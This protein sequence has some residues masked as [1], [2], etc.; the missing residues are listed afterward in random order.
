MKVID[1]FCGAG[2]FSEGLR[3]AGHEVILAVDNWEPALKTHE[4]NHSDCEHWNDDIT[5]IP[6]ETYPKA[7]IIIGSPPCQKFSKA[8]GT[9]MD[10]DAE[11]T[12]KALQVIKAVKPKYWL[13]EN[14]SMW[15]KWVKTLGVGNHSIKNAMYC[16]VPQVRKRHFIGKIPPIMHVQKKPIPAYK[17][18]NLR[19]TDWVH[20]ETYHAQHGKTWKS[21]A[22]PMWTL[23]TK[24]RLVFHSKYD[25]DKNS[26]TKIRRITP[27]D[28][29]RLQAFPD[30][31]IFVGSK[32][33]LF[34][35]IGN[36]IPPPMAQS[37]FKG[38][39]LEG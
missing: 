39:S 25:P 8:R 1:L 14:V 5:L 6:P 34:R 30:D 19:P 26:D 17:C 23:D 15:G 7:D 3:I 20:K 27:R 12:L 37:F 31:Y 35:L 9:G 16:G 21:L 33:N 2:G 32:T 10:I 24:G 29:A 28:A 4:L 11:P 22:R 38:F 36:A 13:L 18:L